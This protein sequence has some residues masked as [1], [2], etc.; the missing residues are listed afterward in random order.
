VTIASACNRYWRKKHVPQNTIA[1]R[2]PR[3]WSG[4]PTNQSVKALKWLA[5]QEHLLRQQPSTSQ[6]PGDRIRSTTN[7][8]EMRVG[9]KQ[10]LVD[11]YDASTNTVYEFHGCLWHGCPKCFKNSR[12]SYS[13]VHPDRTLYEVH[14]HT[15]V[16]IKTLRD[17]GH[18]VIEKWECEWD[19]D[20]KTDPELQHF[21]DVDYK[22]VDPLQPRDAFFG[23]RTN[24]VKY[25]TSPSH[26]TRKDQVHGRDVLVPLGQQ[27]R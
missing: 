4:A 14:E 20:V 7:G 2:P 24:A 25:F 13:T 3:G 5:W 18:R 17:H 23:G 12:H 27:D 10:V 19:Q 9:P 16:K 1:S 22:N 6:A 8:G 26:W 11:G 21:L 15:K